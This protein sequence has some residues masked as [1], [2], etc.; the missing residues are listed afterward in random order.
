VGEE[1]S[2]TVNSLTFSKWILSKN[3]KSKIWNKYWKWLWWTV[4]S[5]WWTI[6]P[7]A[8]LHESIP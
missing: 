3:L 1:S 5:G 7:P 6:T 4:Q 2:L 8:F